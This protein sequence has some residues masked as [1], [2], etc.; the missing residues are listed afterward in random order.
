M[1]KEFLFEI[2]LRSFEKAKEH[3]N[4]SCAKPSIMTKQPFKVQAPKNG[5]ER[6]K[7]TVKNAYR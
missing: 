6:L 3:E 7:T 4:P 5:V 1:L 2:A